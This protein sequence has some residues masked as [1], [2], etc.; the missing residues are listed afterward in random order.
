MANFDE[1][2]A[3]ASDQT[4]QQNQSRRHTY[5]EGVKVLYMQENNKTGVKKIFFRLLPAF[6]SDVQDPQAAATSWVPSILPDGTISQI[7]CFLFSAK[8]CGR[9]DFKTRH[10][11]VSRKTADRSARCPYDILCSFIRNNK[12]DWG[13][14][15]EDVG[16]FRQPGYAKAPLS[17]IQPRL[18]ANVIDVYDQTATVKIGEF[19]QTAWRSL[20]ARGDKPGLMFTKNNAVPPE[21]LQ[22]SYLYQYANGDLTDPENGLVLEV[23]R[24]DSPNASFQG[25]TVNTAKTQDGSPWRMQVSPQQLAARYDIRSAANIVNIPE[26]Q[27][28]VD[29]LVSILD[30]RSPKGYHERALLKMAFADYGWSVPEPPSA[31]A[32]TNTVSVPVAVQPPVQVK[33]AEQPTLVVQRTPVQIKQAVQPTQPPYV[34]TIQPAP[35]Q[36]AAAQP[37]APAAP[38]QTGFVPSPGYRGVAGE[39][40][41]MSRDEILAKLGANR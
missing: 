30:Q 16:K 1:M 32:A 33:Q 3:Y 14:L 37:P 41:A 2:L 13:Y 4:S 5:K 26:E 7:G 15:F 40:P 8:F 10:E 23:S 35:V 12:S 39:T 17:Q 29:E 6:R 21:W 20:M 38:V 24:D 11:I 34:P 27:E 31:P 19:S 28:L 9:G 18:L 36:Q 22:Q 25:Y